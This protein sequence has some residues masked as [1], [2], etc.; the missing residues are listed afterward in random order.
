MF[1]ML[2]ELRVRGACL[3][4]LHVTKQSGDREAMRRYFGGRYYEIGFVGKAQ[5]TPLSRLQRLHAR[6]RPEPFQYNKFVDDWYDDSVQPKIKAVAAEVA[7][8]VVLA[9]YVMMS[10]AL[11]C[12][13]A[14]VLKLID[15]HDLFANRYRKFLAAGQSPRWFSAFPRDEIRALSRADKVIAIQ[16]EEARYL[17]KSLK[18]KVFTIGHI[19]PVVDLGPAPGDKLLFVGGANAINVDAYGYFV[20]EIL[21]RIRARVPTAELL[22]VGTVCDEVEPGEGIRLRGEMP[23]LD[24]VY[25]LAEVV[26]NPCRFGT[27][28][29][30]KNVEAMAFGRCLVTT[31]HGA[32]GL[33][34]GGSSF[35]VGVDAVDF[36]ARTVS[37]LSDAS[38]RSRQA[39]AAV[40]FAK[41][42]H[43]EQRIALEAVFELSA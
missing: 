39:A 5:P 28:L 6:L 9:E 32:V 41:R 21:P 35:Q 38:G 17:R 18:R 23:N 25:R 3:S 37:L 30:T 10:K 16:N 31:P 42:W 20:A 13:P 4:F 36:A 33:G 29:K 1:N 24:D 34:S 7:P 15:T 40:D 12:F 14:H 11:A 22:V 26:V 2:E 8:D 43:R 19:A 27:G